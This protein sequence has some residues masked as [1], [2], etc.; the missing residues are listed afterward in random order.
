M[1]RS[2]RY[3]DGC[4]SKRD[5]QA[6]RVVAIVA[7]AAVSVFDVVQIGFS[8][9]KQGGVHFDKIAIRYVFNS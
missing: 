3:T 1:H 7:T 8:A 6:D 9:Q 2:R 4:V 5:D